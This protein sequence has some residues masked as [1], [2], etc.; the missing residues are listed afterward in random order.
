M[1]MLVVL[2]DWGGVVAVVVAV[3]G[4]F[5]FVVAEVVGRRLLGC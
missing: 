2:R 5:V 1:P 3:V 4:G